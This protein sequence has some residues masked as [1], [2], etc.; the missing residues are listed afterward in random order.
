M[1]AIKGMSNAELLNQTST[2]KLIRF[3]NKNNTQDFTLYFDKKILQDGERIFAYS[4]VDYS[5]VNS[6]ETS[7]PV[8]NYE[9]EFRDFLISHIL[10]TCNQAD[11]QNLD[12]RIYRGKK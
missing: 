5:W 4:W 9:N 7:A 6:G 2:E 10:D 8:I 11:I 1:N 12:R 3:F